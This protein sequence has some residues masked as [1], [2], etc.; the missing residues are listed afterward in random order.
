M[1]G[2]IFGTCVFIAIYVG[3]VFSIN[4]YVQKDLTDDRIKEEYR[5]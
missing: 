4:N 5:K 3:G 1:F 2:I